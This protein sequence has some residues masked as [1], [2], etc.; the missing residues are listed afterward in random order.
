MNEPNFNVS[1]GGISAG[2]WALMMLFGGW[3][4][5][6]YAAGGHDIAILSAIWIVGGYYIGRSSG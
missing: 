1:I 3:P 6:L 2:H 5:L 4:A